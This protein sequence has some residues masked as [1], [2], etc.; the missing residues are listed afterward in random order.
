M[1]LE[2]LTPET[3]FYS[4]EVDSITLP[5]TLGSFQILNNHAPII[6]SLKKGMLSFTAEGRIQEMEVVDGF[7]EINHNKV[8]VCL[9]SI[10][11][12]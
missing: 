10:K 12:L 11:G 2:I 8:T 3:T 5:G 6:S 1:Y 9:D 7:V 4:G